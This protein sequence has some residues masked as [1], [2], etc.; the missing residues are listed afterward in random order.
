[1]ARKVEVKLVDDLDGSRAD[2]TLRFGCDGINYEIDLSA[3][4]AEQLRKALAQFILNGRRVGRSGVTPTRGHTTGARPTRV[5]RAQN[6]AV[7]EWAK[8]KGIELNDRGRIPRTVVE[9]YQ[10][11]AGR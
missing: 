1:M 2:E 6:Q 8:G 11:E 5:D 9:Q 7:R 10:S 4:H 3:P